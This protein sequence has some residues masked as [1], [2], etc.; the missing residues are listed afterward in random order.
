MRHSL[1]FCVAAAGLASPALADHP[2]PSAIGGTAG[3]IN[4]V[5]PETLE[6]GRAAAGFR[7]MFTDP[8]AR[9]DAEL[10]DFA[11]RHVHAHGSASVVNAS[12]GMAYGITDRLTL[13]AELPFA[14]HD[15]IRT[16]EHSHSGGQAHNRAVGLGSVAG[17]GD[18]TILAKY[19]LID[20]LAVLSGL[21][22]PT[23]AT[24]RRASDG[25]RFETEHQPGSGAISPIVGAAAG[26]Q[27][28]AVGVNVS[29]LY[30]F[31]GEGA[32]QTRLGDRFQGGISVARRFEAP[33]R[34]PEPAEH[35]H[36]EGTPAHDHQVENHGHASWDAFVEMTGE[37]E[38][39]QTIAG[40]VESD[41]GG[42]AIWVSP[43]ARYNSAGGWSAAFSFGLPVWQR[44]RASHPDNDYRLTLSI[45]RSF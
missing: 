5:G 37:W 34:H 4:V 16:G 45:G 21:K 1:M 35:H 40:V 12:L 33:H 42:K 2:A 32:Q 8:A 19:R 30:Q 18:L 23:G 44:I 13:S 11:S 26:T 28:G 36:A 24:H 6:A 27:L 14:R 10:V 41:S 39:R 43:G 38:G 15:D 7:L 3:S 22:L 25:A 20:G 9:S 17:I 31:S 29:A